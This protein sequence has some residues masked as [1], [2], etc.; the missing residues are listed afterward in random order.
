[1]QKKGRKQRDIKFYSQKNDCIVIVH[2]EREQVYA[3]KLEDDFDVAG[4]TYGKS[5]E[6]AIVDR[7]QHVKIRKAFLEENWLTDFY[8]ISRTGTISVREMTSTNAL[9]KLAEVEKLELSRRY[10]QFLGITDWKVVI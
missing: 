9:A 5:L 6:P 2:S 7:I 4:Y 8:I 1:M 10:W 3:Q